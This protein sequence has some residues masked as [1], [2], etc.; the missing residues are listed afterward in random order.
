MGPRAR[1]QGSREK[2][3]GQMGRGLTVHGAAGALAESHWAVQLQRRAEGQDLPPGRGQMRQLPADGW[4][5][6]PCRPCL[7]RP[8]GT[9]SS[10]VNATE[11]MSTLVNYIEPVKFKS[12]EAARS[13]W[14]RRW[15]E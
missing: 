5:A 15:W 6:W 9:A 1:R 4:G 14:G 7:W 11:E 2:P 13:E 8:Q 12:F 3:V 10:E